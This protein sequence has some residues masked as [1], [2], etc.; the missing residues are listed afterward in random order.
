MMKTCGACTACCELLEAS[1]I[2]KPAGTRCRHCIVGGCGIYQHR[3]DSCRK[4]ACGWLMVPA[5]P[6]E[7]R[8]DRCG[9]I[10]LPHS[11]ARLTQLVVNWRR[12]KERP[13]LRKVL[14]AFTEHLISHGH[15]VVYNDVDD[16]PCWRVAPGHDLATLKRALQWANSP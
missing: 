8:P 11:A 15:S 6:D 14:D 1:E 10:T 12:M 4:F 2:D 3:P 7:L 5:L 16:S 13:R 9:F